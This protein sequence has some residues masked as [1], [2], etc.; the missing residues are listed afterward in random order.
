MKTNANNYSVFKTNT[1]FKKL[2]YKVIL[3]I[4]L[5]WTIIAPAQ[6]ILNEMYDLYGSR[7]KTYFENEAESIG[8]Y[9]VSKVSEATEVPENTDVSKKP[10]VEKKE[11]S[12]K[13]PTLPKKTVISTK[14]LTNSI[15][16][17]D[18]DIGRI[19]VSKEIPLDNPSDNIFNIQIEQLP[20]LQFSDKILLKYDVEGV[21]GQNAVSRS[22]NGRAAFGGYLVKKTKGWNT[23]EEVLNQDWLKKGTN[24]ILFTT[25]Q[26]AAHQ[27]RIKNV[28]IEI[29]KGV[30]NKV[31]SLIVIQEKNIQIAK[32]DRFYV[33][34]FVKGATQGN[35]SVS[36]GNTPLQVYNNE[37]EGFV[38]IK[39][40]TIVN[41][42]IP[43]KAI[44]QTGL[45][46]QEL[47]FINDNLIQADYTYPLDTKK[48][49][50]KVSAITAE[51][52]PSFG[53]AIELD[54]SAFPKANI[55]I[56]KLRKIDIAPL[57]SGMYN[58]TKGAK[59]Y[60]VQSLQ[61]I[62]DTD[63]KLKLKYDPAMIPNGYTAKDIKTFYFNKENKSWNILQKDSLDLEKSTL[64]SF[65]TLMNQGE[66]TDYINGIIQTPESPQTSSFLPTMMNDIKPVNPSSN[67]ALIA[68]PTASQQGN[69]NLSYPIRIPA[70]RNGMQPSVGLQYNDEGGNGW[71]GLGW[72]ISTP[73]VSIDTR[74]GA[75]TFNNSQETELYSIGGEM[76]MYPD[77]YLPHR[78]QGDTP[79]EFTTIP[80][81]RS[82]HFNGGI[83]IF[84]PRKQG[85]FARI[86]RIGNSPSNYYWKVTDAYGT[87]SW[88]GGGP[89]G[90]NTNSVVVNDSGNIVH[91]GLTL[92][93]D[94]FGNNMKYTYRNETFP[95]STTNNL[96]GG[97]YFYLNTIKYTGHNGT[98]GNYEV[99]FHIQNNVKDDASINGKL[100][101]KWID[102]YLLE[103]IDVKHQNNLIRYYDLQYKDELGRFTKNLLEVVTERD[104]D[105]N[106]FYSHDFEYYD[107][108][109]TSGGN[110][111][112]TPVDID[113][114]ELGTSFANNFG[115]QL[116]S[117][118]AINS[119]ENI[120][121]GYNA[122]VSAGVEFRLGV[123]SQNKRKSFTIG[124]PF[125]ENSFRSKGKIS[126][127]DIN[128]DGIDDVVYRTTNGLEFLPGGLIATSD[129]S[130][131]FINDFNDGPVQINN[132][133]DFYRSNGFSK[134][135]FGESY[136]IYTAL[137]GPLS[138][139][140][141]T[142]RIKTR[143]ESNIYFT[144]G[145]GD[146]LIDIV[147]DEVVYFNT[148]DPDTG[149]PTF[150]SKSEDTENMVI[151]A[152][153]IGEPTDP[154]PDLD[155]DPELEQTLLDFDAVR[156]WIAPFD[157]T[158]VINDHIR[159]NNTT[160]TI[161]TATEEFNNNIPFRIFATEMTNITQAV[162]LTHYENGA[163]LGIETSSTINVTRG[164]RIY[165]R[166]HSNNSNPIVRSNPSIN[167]TFTNTENENGFDINSYNYLTN[168]QL[169][170]ASGFTF[171][172]N[173]NAIISFPQISTSNPS[174]VVTFKIT[175]RVFDENGDL[176]GLPI[177]I[178][179]EEFDS[180]TSGTTI[181][182]ANIITQ[183]QSLTNN[184]H[185]SIINFEVLSDSNPYE[186]RH[187]PH[188]WA[189][190]VL[191][192]SE[193]GESFIDYIVPNFSV[194][195][196][197]KSSI[198]YAE[199]LNINNWDITLPQNVNIGVR[200]H[201]ISG[202]PSPFNTTDNGEFQFI[203]KNNNGT[204][205][206]RLITIENGVI[207]INNTTPIANIF[208]G[209]LATTTDQNLTNFY[210]G[211]YADGMTN[212][213]LVKK[214]LEAT[215]TTNGDASVEISYDFSNPSASYTTSAIEF[216]KNEYP[217]LGPLN[218]GWGQ[219]FY[220]ENYDGGEQPSDATGNLI[221]P[222]IVD[223]PQL[224]I[225][226]NIGDCP[227]DEN[228]ADCVASNLGIPT[229]E[230]TEFTEESLQELF[231][232]I[233]QSLI[234][235]NFQ[236]PEISFIPGI[237]EY[238]QKNSRFDRWIGLSRDQYIAKF[239][240][241]NVNFATSGGGSNSG[242]GNSG[243]FNGI[244]QEN[245]Q[246]GDWEAMDTNTGMH[247]INKKQAS[248]TR[249]FA[250]GFGPL[251]LNISKSDNDGNGYSRVISEF[252]DING[253]RYPDPIFPNQAVVSNMTGGHTQGFINHDTGYPSVMDNQ[254]QAFSISGSTADFRNDQSNASSNTNVSATDKGTV[255]T[256][257]IGPLDASIG[258]S[259][260][261][262]NNNGSR[263]ESIFMDVNGDGLPDRITEDQGSYKYQ[264]N[265]GSFTL[266][267]NPLEIY[268]NL[269]IGTSEPSPINLNAG[270]G[271][272]VNFASSFTD[273][274]GTL[275]QILGGA[276]AF[277]AG[278][279]G[280]SSTTKST[281]QD[282]NGDG[283][284]DI[285]VTNGNFSQVLFNNGQ[286]FASAQPLTVG[287]PTLITPNLHKD[288]RSRAVS[289]S[290][291]GSAYFG[292]PV[293][294]PIFLPPFFLP[295]IHVKF[296]ATLGGSMSLSIADT[297]EVFK[298]FNGD[299]FTDYVQ[300]NGNDFRV[301][302]STIGRTNKLKTVHNPLGGSFTIDYN[303]IKKTYDN[304][305][306]KW[307]M[308]SVI[309]DD[310]YHDI[311]NDGEDQY[312][313]EFAYQGARYDRRERMFYGFETVRVFDYED[314]LETVYRSTE[315]IYH[316]RSYFLQGL[317]KSST[318]MREGPTLSDSNTTVE[319]R[320][321]TTT[322]TYTIYGLE[323]DNQ[324]IDLTTIHPEDFDTGGREGRKT[325]SVLLTKTENK[326]F[327]LTDAP[328]ESE[329][330][331]E[332]DNL[333][334]VTLYTNLGDITNS[335]HDYTSTI[336]YHETSGLLSQ[337]LIH[338]PK[339]IQVHIGTELKRERITQNINPTT[340][341]I[342][343]INARID[344]QTLATTTM[345][346]DIY[347][348]LS[349]VTYPENLNGEQMFYQY[350][351]DT[352][353]NK[354]IIET[355]DAFGYNSTAVYDP[356]FDT[357]LETID[358]A[359]NP[360]TYQY[361]S[362][363]RTIRITGPKE[364]GNTDAFT[365]KC[366]YFIKPEQLNGI[367]SIAEADFLPVGR[368]E[369]YD[370]QN[371]TNTIDTYTFIDGL[372]RTVQLKKDIRLVSPSAI[373]DEQLSISGKTT[374]DHLGRSIR[375]YHPG[376][377]PKNTNTNFTINND[378]NI[379]FFSEIVYDEL[380]RAIQTTDEA[381]FNVFTEYTVESSSLHRTTTRA[382]QTDTTNSTNI[383][384]TDALGRTVKTIQVGPDGNLETQFTYNAISEMEAYTDAE[385]I[386]TICE[387]DLLG[388]KIA[389]LH[390]DN[391]TTTTEYDNAN[392]VI[393]VITEKMGLND[394]S[395]TY[396]YE[397]N[398]LLQSI[399][400]SQGLEPNIANVTY[401]YGDVDSGNN[402]GRIIYQEDATGIQHFRYGNMGELTAN[403]RTIVAPNLP[404]RNFRTNF[405]YD[406]WN[407]VLDVT[408]P[409][410]EKV[411][412][413][414]DHGGN[415]QQ[416]TGKVQGQDY[417]YIE[418]INYD[419]FG[420][421]IS[422]QM[423]NGTSA[424]YTYEP[425]LRRLSTHRLLDAN[426]K[427]LLN[428]NYTYDKLDNV[429]R[430]VNSAGSD[431]THNLGGIYRH[432][433]RYDILN[434]LTSA[435]GR[436]TGSTT[437][438]Q[439]RSRYSL[440][441]AYND[442]HG[443]AQKKQQH[444]INGVVSPD[445]TYDRVYE[446]TPGT[447]KVDKIVE[448]ATGFEIQYTY[449]A[450]GNTSAVQ[451]TNG[452]GVRYFW[453]ETNRL[454][455]VNDG[456]MMQHYIYDASDERVLKSSSDPTQIN[457]NGSPVIPASVTFENYTTYPSNL[458][459]VRPD[460]DY[461]KHYFNG[462][463]RITT[464]IG[465]EEGTFFDLA[466]L[467]GPDQD[468]LKNIKQR[469]IQNLQKI[470]LESGVGTVSFKEFIVPD[471]KRQASEREAITKSN[472]KNTGIIGPISTS[473][474]QG[475]Y[476][477]HGDHLGTAN[478]ITDA[479]G[480]GY[481]FFNTLPFGETMVEQHSLQ[482]DYE[483]RWQFNGKE[484]DRETGLYYYGARYYNPNTSIWLSVDPL[485][486]EREW[487]SPYN[488]VQNNPINRIDPD[489][490]LDEP[491][492]G[493]DGTYRGDTRE[494][495][496]GEVIIYDGDVDFSKMSASDLLSTKGA[497]TYDNQRGSLTGDAKSNIWTHIASQLEG[498]QIYD[499]TFSM[500]DL[501]GGKIHFDYARRPKGS[502]VSSYV[503]GKGKGKIRGSD[504]YS[505]S[506]TVENIQSSVVVHEWYS[507]I[508]KNNGGG[509]DSHRLAYKNV[510]NFKS[511]WNNTTDG[512][513][514]FNM[515]GLL[516]YTK[517]ESNNRK[518][519]VDPLYR[520][521]YKKYHKKY[522]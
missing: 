448:D 424:T 440:A 285:L 520:N 462:S 314:D 493:S 399:F 12:K 346:Y 324:H 230:N 512:Y 175:Q 64:I 305:N 5:H 14:K 256:T 54:D 205:G 407:R 290:I 316:N 345:D 498:Q 192:T 92:V 458:I 43:V 518:T 410:G 115:S 124:A 178:L 142:K 429:L 164:Q 400:P 188:R 308:K 388:R 394:E 53:I 231:A 106:E 79:G 266:S 455:V 217:H 237:P 212:K 365:I 98:D 427:V 134:T 148:I 239:T 474:T 10:I 332:Y 270:F 44:D 339:D 522:D 470:A 177:I 295:L 306:A 433:Y 69:A 240:I 469:Q 127:T 437:Q 117:K 51:K 517:S 445:N 128:G 457:E 387:Y 7:L 100:G 49:Q 153:G 146:N 145:N 257:N 310:G 509:F 77:N 297:Q 376:F 487:L 464:R 378:E 383:S 280:S 187:G 88:Y 39:E 510:I 236:F 363:G 6:P 3:F 122:G 515:R 166:V 50:T 374:Y 319:N 300:E 67:I 395:I 299:G 264:L 361:D 275:S 118:S 213:I 73:S 176:V 194:Y 8:T 404:N 204:I 375:Q 186:W 202:S 304:P 235:N 472:D 331:M 337:N 284:T 76:L 252:K 28:R 143:S 233:D 357:L 277:N 507:H 31:E 248:S 367:A 227:Q 311:V 87:I 11:K 1:R 359:G 351:Y 391:G 111:Y 254:N 135:V 198:N 265:K 416:V 38:S 112:K 139:F 514:G 343:R 114:P 245:D 291:Q 441:M 113:I 348:N 450:N 260:N 370:V 13:N 126:L 207:S 279:S 203:V 136:E 519:Q 219:F 303:A 60:R 276:L 325:A 413:T 465:E 162:N 130:T 251:A 48:Y 341:T 330:Q 195:R 107:D 354:Y 283:L 262:G 398:R 414:Y 59:G 72:N 366:S 347:G 161:E 150:V 185:T 25:P 37:F 91:W 232:T 182:Q 453:D 65:A 447:H 152:S 483:N 476:F 30:E 84:T 460:G 172:G 309:V 490:A 459:V 110:L 434:R 329:M 116:L 151:T 505:Y 468:L 93:E 29:E 56:T 62:P 238:S 499:E 344:G 66:G 380:D 171:P 508:K 35:V 326:V 302:Y 206:K 491:V 335:S 125:G 385:D 475:I 323:N 120:E 96:S 160:Y 26:N 226:F 58:V 293:C 373:G 27:Y 183:P 349:K 23:Q 19:G 42:M 41:G 193:Q 220:N 211:F 224:S 75:P 436:F 318:V 249:T 168:T 200:P 421:T 298:D 356:E 377:E 333:G 503:L 438:D 382:E 103:R 267:D 442:T 133:S 52:T 71:V 129:G 229:D 482:E 140:G 463:S 165:F 397:Y 511:L 288:A 488:F 372:A 199:I 40:Q 471:D 156:V 159:G 486:E 179:D 390:P 480:D 36:V 502:W 272:G 278:I 158:I 55:A 287:G 17:A 340:G 415:L 396:K 403:D 411:N 70:G 360:I 336:T 282:I 209:N 443:I 22:I 109:A 352:L 426:N 2:S 381:G 201:I 467:G 78:H 86:E 32:G 461:T 313:T 169:S 191:F 521:L 296:G 444:R 123:H 184:N 412:Y 501:K 496:T 105:G 425:A 246:E 334:R 74:W 364:Q 102:P 419:H 405:T 263:E 409:D 247:A 163:P 479:S 82:E 94:V 18:L 132:A 418:N 216:Y 392:N 81:G 258:V 218:R 358:I 420:Q 225:D 190:E 384:F 4:T 141:T 180:T 89:S 327:E 342:G 321:S 138:F 423:G 243:P 208:Q 484:L 485:A 101:L 386:S 181:S 516:K 108:V 45:L 432:N 292:F 506:T 481:Q 389:R 210:M 121:T 271:G 244:I 504:K 221:N 90:L 466:T 353:E 144:D 473:P 492:Y 393:E 315:S 452:G 402:T 173:G 189:P 495:F 268:T 99:S 435:R 83:K 137:G 274:A 430:L 234:D 500:S 454:R 34:G 320:F 228:Y 214:Y 119:S 80:Q 317:M 478:F 379:V 312:L 242:G 401:S 301:F 513:K 223:N 294:C 222:D 16:N 368:T 269:N 170:E 446:Y 97:T 20:D 422:K 104:K 428:N 149:E 259:A 439:S 154:D 63:F 46:G 369:H 68:P 9:T 167:Y 497:D 338:I 406:S 456:I 431:N 494:G 322:N 197:T 174:D 355:R 24:E 477:F 250:A 281:L 350:G 47:L 131:D 253:D 196:A 15:Y 157:G 155:E 85:S 307:V 408:Y 273:Q 95:T 61:S 33:K 286:N 147:S 449:D 261:V 241:Q 362:F 451:D 21:Q 289:A 371:P 328:I 57:E 417:N 489:G 215:Q 255:T